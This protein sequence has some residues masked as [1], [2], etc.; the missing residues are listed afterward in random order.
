MRI[1]LGVFPP[2]EIV[3]DFRSFKQQ[4]KK[5]KQNLR[6]IPAPDIHLTVKFLG[7][8]VSQASAGFVKDVIGNTLKTQTP[9]DVTIRDV[10]FGLPQDTKSRLLI[11]EIEESEELENLVER[12]DAELARKN[13]KDVYPR[14]RRF[15][16]HITL[17]RIHSNYHSK[18]IR[19]I[20]DAIDQAIFE[21]AGRTF[22]VNMIKM[23]NA[24]PVK[25]GQVYR[26]LKEYKLSEE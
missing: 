17:A 20:N 4:L 21:S 24:E 23:I 15:I 26:V 3:D 2:R 19:E 14:R 6:F 25:D 10:R 8:N 11:A 9:F 12:I 16:P 5:Q 13:L 1:F 18:K 22:T 7:T